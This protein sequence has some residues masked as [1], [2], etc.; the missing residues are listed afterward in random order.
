MRS[1]TDWRKRTSLIFP[2][3]ISID[4]LAIHPERRMIRLV[5]STKCEVTHRTNDLV[6]PT[7]SSP[8]A[9]RA[10]TT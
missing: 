7:R 3:G 1:T 8:T 6:G 10:V 4:S 9:I 2:S 5:V